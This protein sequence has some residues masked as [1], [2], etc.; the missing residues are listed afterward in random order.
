MGNVL[1]HL[2]QERRKQVRPLQPGKREPAHDDV[3]A[4]EERRGRAATQGALRDEV[5]ERARRGRGV[6]GERGGR[7]RDGDAVSVPRAL[8]AHETVPDASAEA[9]PARESLHRASSGSDSDH[10]TTESTPVTRRTRP[11]TWSAM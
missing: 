8:H 5:R 2:E 10:A 11:F 3:V 4:F 9:N 1:P 6:A 7:A